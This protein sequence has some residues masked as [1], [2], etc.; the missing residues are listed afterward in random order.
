MGR[1]LVPR[2][3][4]ALELSAFDDTELHKLVA[5]V[6]A[7]SKTSPLV[8]GDPTLAVII[9]ALATSDADLTTAGTA[10]DTDRNKLRLDIAAEAKARSVVVGF[11]RLV[12]TAVT[13]VAASPAE[14]QA[15]GLPA[16]PPRVPANQPPATPQQ[17]DVTFPR[18]GHGKATVTVHE[19]GTRRHAYAAQQSLDGVHWIQLGVG[20]GKT[21]AVTGAS[22]SQL[23]VRFA[24]VR[25]Q[26]QSPW[27]TP[28]LVTLP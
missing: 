10:V 3:L 19:T 13:N 25:G 8:L 26:L 11:L 20:Q 16:A 6:V 4:A 27:S 9:A 28:V 23:W 5:D 2:Y 14:V 24:M 17:L 22:G 15:A 18:T 1:T 12:V 7:S 21:R